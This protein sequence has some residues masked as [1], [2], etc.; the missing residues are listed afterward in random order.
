MR[1]H[2]VDNTVVVT[3]GNMKQAHFTENWVYHLRKLGVG[4]LLV[5]MMNM[6]FDQPRYVRLAAKLRPLGV[7]VYTVNSPEVR[8]QPQG[9]RWF[10]VLPLL[11]TGARV[12]LSDSD[13]VWLR[14]PRP[15]FP[16]EVTRSCWLCRWAPWPS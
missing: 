4:G 5:G 6:R 1:R 15:Y 12:L 9:G 14:D 8:R 13:A 3:F 11:R 16:A 7:G 2:A 10:H